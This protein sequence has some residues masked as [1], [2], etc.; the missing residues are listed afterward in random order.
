VRQAPLVH[1][2]EDQ[3]RDHAHAGGPGGTTDDR[4][5]GDGQRAVTAA[6]D[7][8]ESPPD[9]GSERAAQDRGGEEEGRREA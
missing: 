8:D 4:P 7:V 6:A 9:A 1:G 5:G 3:H 2:P